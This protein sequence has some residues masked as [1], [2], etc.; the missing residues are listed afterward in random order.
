M[1]EYAHAGGTC[2]FEPTVFDAP[3]IEQWLQNM[4][5]DKDGTWGWLVLGKDDK[6]VKFMVQLEKFSSTMNHPVP[7]FEFSLLGAE[8]K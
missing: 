5:E 7:Y 6:R 3:M 1:K 8:V 4:W 2:L